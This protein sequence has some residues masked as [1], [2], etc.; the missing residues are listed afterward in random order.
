MRR[1]LRADLAALCISLV[2]AGAIVALDL[3]TSAE[4]SEPRTALMSVDAAVAAAQEQGASAE[5][6][7]S[8]FPVYDGEHDARVWRVVG[9][10][11]AVIDAQTG[12]LLEISFD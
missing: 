7:R 9:E 10:D 5:Q 12:E 8:P 4:A 11:T 2:G 3:Q 1:D 6:V